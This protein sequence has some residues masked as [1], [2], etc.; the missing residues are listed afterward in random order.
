MKNS[1]QKIKNA[2][3]LIALF[4]GVATI[5]AQETAV[6]SA[7][8]TIVT[9]NTIEKIDD[10]DFGDLISTDV[11]GTV[12]LGTDGTRTFAGPVASATPGNVN[13]AQFEV[14]GTALALY[15]ITT[16]TTIILTNQDGYTMEVDTFT[17]ATVL[18]LGVMGTLPNN[19]KQKFYLGSTLHV[20]ANQ[21]S[22]LYTNTTDLTVTINF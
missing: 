18:P 19:G 12:I 1:T 20:S 10:I 2:F 15:T 11:A 22:G 8:A 9:S 4:F 17:S 3:V 6:A 21:Q 13:P 16:P 7:A 5:N 14:I